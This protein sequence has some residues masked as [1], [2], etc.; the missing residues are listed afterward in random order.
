MTHHFTTMH[1]FI[2]D[3]LEPSAPPVEA[4]ASKIEQNN[5]ALPD[6]PQV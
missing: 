6:A 2:L 3:D 5:K 1:A 4:D